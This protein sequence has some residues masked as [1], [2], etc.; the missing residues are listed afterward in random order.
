MGDPGNPSNPN[1][2]SEPD[3]DQPGWASPTPPPPSTPPS[4]TP[5]PEPQAPIAAPVPPE[6]A[7]T[8]PQPQAPV[9]APSAAPA[10]GTPPP[11]WGT[12]PPV[13]PTPPAAAGGGWTPGPKP[14]KRRLTWLWILIPVLLV[15]VAST[16]V[17]IV[18]VVKLAL[19]PVQTT[20]DYYA[21]LHH[22]DYAAAYGKLCFAIQRD[23]PEGRYIALQASDARSKGAVDD[24]DFSSSHIEN[25]NAT[26]T[27][28]VTRAG[29]Q[30][31][32]TIGLR[33]ENGDWKVCSIRE[34]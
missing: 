12:P 7:P 2:G 30:Y 33:K 17:V 24:Y 6:P 21:D 13:A 22:R 18:F 1:V 23:V 8:A 27:G 32:A 11:V 25:G 4:E 34:R 29:Q 31:N 28:T 20:N 10:W 19:G 14:K 3:P 26:T 16:V 9:T 15:F 5:P